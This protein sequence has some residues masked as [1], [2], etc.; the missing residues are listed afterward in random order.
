MIDLKHQ[1]AGIWMRHEA[2]KMFKYKQYLVYCE[3]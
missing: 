1:T 3:N 2:K